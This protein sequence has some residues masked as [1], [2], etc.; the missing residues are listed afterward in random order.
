MNTPLTL[1]S[2]IQSSRLLIL[3]FTLIEISNSIQSRLPG[4]RYIVVGTHC[5]A[6]SEITIDK[7]QVMERNGFPNSLHPIHQCAHYLFHRID[8]S[9]GEQVQCPR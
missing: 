9:E 6:K 5:E 4:A 1:S 7:K 3:L 2:P 8:Q